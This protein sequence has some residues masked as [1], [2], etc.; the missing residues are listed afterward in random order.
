MLLITI[1]QYLGALIEFL[2]SSFKLIALLSI[3]KSLTD[4]VI[5]SNLIPFWANPTLKSLATP[6]WP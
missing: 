4:G 2:T 6:W 5:S 3:L 1:P